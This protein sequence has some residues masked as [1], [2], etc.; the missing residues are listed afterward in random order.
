MRERKIVKVVGRNQFALLLRALNISSELMRNKRLLSTH[1][2]SINSVKLRSRASSISFI[3]KA[4]VP[5][6]LR[7]IESAER[8]KGKNYEQEIDEESSLILSRTRKKPNIP[9][10]LQMEK[11]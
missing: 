7:S 11:N 4:R 6:R 1:S 10:S 9:A 5:R 2:V 3:M 8:K